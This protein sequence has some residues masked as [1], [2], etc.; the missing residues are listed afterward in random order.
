MP[1]PTKVTESQIIS[2]LHKRGVYV[3]PIDKNFNALLLQDLKYSFQVAQFLECNYAQH[4]RHTHGT[5]M[6]RALQLGKAP[7]FQY[8]PNT[9]TAGASSYAVNV[10]NTITRGAFD[11]CQLYLDDAL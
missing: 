3:P 9:E 8:V 10:V 7:Y 6:L 1:K 2:L 11:L 4:F 5:M